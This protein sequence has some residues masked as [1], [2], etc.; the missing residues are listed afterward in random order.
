M[1]G[2]LA[3]DQQYTNTLIPRA[4]NASGPHRSVA[5]LSAPIEF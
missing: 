3:P 4:G 5:E 2:R 1:R